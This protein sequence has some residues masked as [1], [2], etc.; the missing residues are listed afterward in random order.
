MNARLLQAN[1]ALSRFHRPARQ[2]YA[3]I[4]ATLIIV[5]GSIAAATV[6]GWSAEKLI[7]YLVEVFW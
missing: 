6:I 2:R 4:V 7:D 1:G 5:T 3:G